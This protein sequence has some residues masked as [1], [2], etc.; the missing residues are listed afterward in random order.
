[1]PAKLN[2][3]AR[4]RNTSLEQP[5]LVPAWGE[6]DARHYA[7]LA[8]RYGRTGVA[9]FIAHPDIERVDLL[10]REAAAGYV[11]VRRWAISPGDVIAA[12]EAFGLALCEYLDLLSA[13]R[14][15]P[16]FVAVGDP[17]PY[18]RLGM[19][20]E[21]IADEAI[22]DLPS[23]SVAGSQRASLRHST[24]SARRAGLTVVPFA[25]SH[26]CQIRDISDE[27]LR[28]K[29]GGELGFTLSRHCDVDAQRAEHSA[30]VWVIVDGDGM[31][32]AWCTWRP[33]LDGQA[34]VLD[35]MRRRVSAPN[36]AMDCLLVTVLETYRDQ[37]LLQASLASVPRDRGVWAN[38][39]YPTRSLRAY[40]QK[41][42]P[43]WCPRWLAI[44]AAWQKP[45]AYTAIGTAYCPDGL[46]RA[47]RHNR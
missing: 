42:Q 23:F 5:A 31:V 35:I 20:T 9:P 22:I 37:G 15:R 40:K 16:A 4:R 44:R 7:R 8:A 34:R 39:V 17:R 27:W 13:R 11:L 24:T 1:V 43:V 29:R 25:S 47:A 26:E 21:E 38:H 45:F 33:Y 6:P 46:R 2:T 18:R 28:T 30:D 32:Q 12:P 41:F 14:L 3:V 36:P 19:F 10:G